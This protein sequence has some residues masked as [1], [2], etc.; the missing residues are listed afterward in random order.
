MSD[1]VYS[2]NPGLSGIIPKPNKDTSE[3]V[4]SQI[5]STRG[6]SPPPM[7]LGEAYSLGAAVERENLSESLDEYIESEVYGGCKMSAQHQEVLEAFVDW[8]LDQ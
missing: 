1:N 3:K 8:H 5:E 4:E 7:T 2:V 6:S